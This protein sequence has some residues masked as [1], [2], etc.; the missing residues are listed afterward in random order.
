MNEYY[1][2]IGIDVGRKR[3]GLAQSDL[4]QTIASPIGAFSGGEIFKKIQDIV[5]QGPVKKFVIGW[6]IKL[7]GEEG[8]SVHMVQSFIGELKKMFPDIEI[9]TLDERFTSVMAKQALIKSGIPKKKRREKGRVDAAAA[10]I[11]LQ[12]Y[13]DNKSDS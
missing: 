9:V 1:R 5:K 12:S 13:L 7:S 4:L 8:E 10:A 2:L 6:P 11:I 3:I